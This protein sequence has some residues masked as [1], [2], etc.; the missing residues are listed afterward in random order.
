MMERHLVPAG[1]KI[2]IH[3]E[4]AQASRADAEKAFRYDPA[5]KAA[6]RGQMSLGAL[7]PCLHCIRDMIPEKTTLRKTMKNSERHV[8][9]ARIEDAPERI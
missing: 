7:R 4:A 6:F 5:I 3:H 1:R 9:I 8:R 2:H